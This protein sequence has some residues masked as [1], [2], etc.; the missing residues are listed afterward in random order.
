MQ[1]FKDLPLHGATSSSTGHGAAPQG[2]GLYEVK[3]PRNTGQI[4]QWHT[5]ASISQVQKYRMEGIMLTE[6]AIIMNYWMPELL[7]AAKSIHFW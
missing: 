3:P 1:P 4:I 7:P 5:D 2:L 6:V